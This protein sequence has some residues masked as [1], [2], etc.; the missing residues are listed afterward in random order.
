VPLRYRAGPWAA[1]VVATER[2][3]VLQPLSMR[4][5]ETVVREFCAAWS[6]RDVD[7]I[8]AWFAA[9]AVYHNMP[10]APVRGHAEI[11][12]VLE[13]FVPPASKIEFEILAVASRGDV[14]FTERVDRFTVG[15]KEIALPV[16]GVFEVRDGKIAAW[17]DYFDMASYQRQLS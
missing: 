12:G 2:D 13:I 14:V 1:K 4:D 9:D 11:R 10:I 3:A 5:P 8:L 16:A 7:A 15:G 6:G 17:R